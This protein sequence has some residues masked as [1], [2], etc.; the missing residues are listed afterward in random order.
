MCSLVDAGF[1][2]DEYSAMVVHSEDETCK[3]VKTRFEYDGDF[4]GNRI[5]KKWTYFSLLVRVIL[6]NINHRYLPYFSFPYRSIHRKIVPAEFHKIT[7][8]K[9]NST[10]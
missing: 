5:K 2:D 4:K 1:E 10:P 6:E 9:P 7:G 3:L 8:I